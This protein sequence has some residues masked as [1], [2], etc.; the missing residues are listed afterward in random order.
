MPSSTWV[1]TSTVCD[2]IWKYQPKS[3]LDIGPGFGRWGF[4]VREMMDVFKGRVHA[5][6]W[7]TRISAIEIFP[8]YLQ[9]HHRHI[10][11]DIIVD[12]ALA[13]TCKFEGITD[14]FDMVIAG[15]VLEH[16]DK[17]AGKQLIDAV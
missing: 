6:Q 17:S 10:Y 1:H 8:K 4:I 5:E 9:A 2:L 15:D 14:V 13:Y 16:F 3:V 12:C 7:Q 11:D